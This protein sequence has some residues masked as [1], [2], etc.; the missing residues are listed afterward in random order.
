VELATIGVTLEDVPGTEGERLL[1]VMERGVLSRYSLLPN[2]VLHIGRATSCDVVLRDPLAS[3]KHAV[4]YTDRGLH[5][6]DLGSQNGT[7]VRNARLAA[8]DRVPVE[9]GDPIQVGGALLIVHRTR[10]AANQWGNVTPDVGPRTVV[11]DPAM[12]AVYALVSRVAVSN[13]NVL[14]SGETGVGKELVAEA[15]H[16]QSGA[17]SAGPYVRINCA[18]LTDTLFESELFGH[19]RGAFT[20]A[21]RAKQGLVE[22][23]H[24]GTAFL[25]EVGELSP[26]VQAKLL[27][28]LE[29]R[30]V[31]RVGAVESRSIDV[32]FVAATNRDLRAE[33]ARGTFRE[34][35]FFRLAGVRIAIPPLRERTTEIVPLMYELA[36]SMATTLGRPLPTFSDDAREL[37]IAYSWPGN[38]RELRNVVESA[39][40]RSDGM[41]I[42]P[43]DLPEEVRSWRATPLPTTDGSVPPGW[44][45]SPIAPLEGLSD[46]QLQERARILDGLATC[47]GNQTRAAELLGMPRRT[48]VHKLAAYAIP[49]PRC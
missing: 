45:T 11:R 14:V 18:A 30:Q 49:R 37:L 39:V 13:L 17:R 36:A 32:R 23:A 43:H 20:G 15:V 29:S 35:L 21:V 16:R 3:R 4:L 46:R 31:T 41:Q 6:E 8:N 19:E 44:S 33:V 47:N 42:T 5:V 2:R 34:D 25:D 38:I 22:S 1:L 24:K 27:R 12:Q 40:V 28:V 7:L 48:L 26:S 9:L 10:S